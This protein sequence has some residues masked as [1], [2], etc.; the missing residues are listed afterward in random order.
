MTPDVVLTPPDSVANDPAAVELMR[1]WWSRNEPAMALKPAVQDPRAFG[2]VLAHAASNMALAYANRGAVTKDE[3]HR[4]ILEGFSATISGPKIE[5][6]VEPSA[7][8][9]R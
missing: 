8:E 3:A 4:A 6:V 7:E 2:V 1:I 9:V 5:T